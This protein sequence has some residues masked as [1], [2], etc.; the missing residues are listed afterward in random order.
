MLTHVDSF[1][2]L[3]V[4]PLAEDGSPLSLLPRAGQSLFSKTGSIRDSRFRRRRSDRR[5]EFLET[6]VQV[7]E[8]RFVLEITLC[9]ERSGDDAEF[10]PQRAKDWLQRD[11]E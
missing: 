1:F 2:F 7:D 4:F 10:V 3:T 6:L 8:D 9:E 5:R 11:G